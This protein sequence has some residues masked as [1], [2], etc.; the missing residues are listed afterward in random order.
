MLAAFL[1][2]Q[3]GASYCFLLLLVRNK[4]FYSASVSL[5]LPSE[6]FTQR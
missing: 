2:G 5:S 1:G 6:V 3:N 4:L